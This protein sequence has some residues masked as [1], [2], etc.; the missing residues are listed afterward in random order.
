MRPASLVSHRLAASAAALVV[1]GGS[2]AVALG[3]TNA[4]PRIRSG[5]TITI[6]VQPVE[7]NADPAVGFYNELTCALLM[8]M[9]DTHESVLVPEVAA[10]WPSVSNGGRRYMFTVRPGF[11]FSDGTRVTAAHFAFAL[12]R[13]LTPRLRSPYARFF[14]V[15]AG[16]R[17]VTSGRATRASGVRASGRRLTIDLTRPVP[18]FATRA[19]F[20]CPVPLG[21]ARAPLGAEA[22]VPAAVVVA[23]SLV[24]LPDPWRGVVAATAFATCAAVA[25][26]VPLWRYAVHRWEVSET[27]VYTQRGWWARERRIA[28]MSRVQTV[29]FA[30]GPLARAF[31]LATVTVTTASA[32]GALRIDGLDRVVALRLVDELTLKADLVEGDAT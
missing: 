20:L 2:A 21:V 10:G 17:A 31:G 14:D 24:F 6:L 5:G 32:A 7:V 9:R 29:D 13:L 4:K 30:Q 16:A 3:E 27:A 26:V 23:A 25:V 15:V 22:R 19:L 28:P 1:A 12:N 8:N 18:D 11:R